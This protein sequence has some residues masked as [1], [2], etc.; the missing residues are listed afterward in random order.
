MQRPENSCIFALQPSQPDIEG[1]DTRRTHAN[2]ADLQGQRRFHHLRRNPL[3][4]YDAELP[5]HTVWHVRRFCERQLRRLHI[6]VKGFQHR[7]TSN[8][9]HHLPLPQNPPQ[10]RPRNQHQR[11]LRRQSLR[12]C[13]ADD[14]LHRPALQGMAR[15]SQ[16]LYLPKLPDSQG[17][18]HPKTPFRNHHA[19]GR[20]VP[21]VGEF[22]QSHQ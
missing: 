5:I 8:R 20:H 10:D 21:D 1:L 18:I 6:A 22:P 4:D 16:Q 15:Q 12:H 13:C 11:S 7:R 14:R 3:R 2:G 19:A 9:Q 17:H